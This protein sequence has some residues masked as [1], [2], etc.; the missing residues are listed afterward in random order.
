M[1]EK[2]FLLKEVGFFGKPI[3]LFIKQAEWGRYFFLPK[4]CEV[5][6]LYLCGFIGISFVISCVL[7]GLSYIFAFR[8]LDYE[9]KLAYECGFEPF[10]SSQLLS[11]ISFCLVAATF[12][13]FDLEIVFLYP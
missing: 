11:E 6:Y 10:S 5:E 1:F 13:L 8:A 3:V 7:L 9:K 4:G 12:V 2:L